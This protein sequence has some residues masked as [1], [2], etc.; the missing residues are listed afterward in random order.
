MYMYL[1]KIKASKKYLS[2]IFICSQ[3]LFDFY[4]DDDD[5]YFDCS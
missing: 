2:D 4:D 1:N 3:S 5:L